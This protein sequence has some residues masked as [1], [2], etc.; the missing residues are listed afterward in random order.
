MRMKAIAAVT[1]GL[2]AVLVAGPASAGGVRVGVGIGVGPG[3]WGGP[4]WGG[5]WGWGPR[6]GIGIGVGPGWWGGPWWGA[7]PW[8]GSPG[9]PG[10]VVVQQPSPAVVVQQ[11]PAPQAPPQ[12]FWYFCPSSRAYYPYV[13]ECPERWLTVVPPSGP[14]PSGPG[15]AYAAPR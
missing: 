5:G 9:W 8:W 3:W 11:P 14:P 6:V 15:A 2:L 7:G 10:P 1:F 4:W 13:S 12:S